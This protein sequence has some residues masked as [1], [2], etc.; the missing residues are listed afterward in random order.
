MLSKCS[1]TNMSVFTN[2]TLVFL[3]L[4]PLSAPTRASLSIVSCCC[5][6]LQTYLTRELVYH[7]N[8]PC[9]GGCCT[10]PE[11]AWR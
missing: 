6:E 3:N 9:S 10:T 4:P 1:T 2:D 11:V 7:V 5:E 8:T